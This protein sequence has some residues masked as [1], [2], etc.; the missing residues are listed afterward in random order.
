MRFLFL[1]NSFTYALILASYIGQ[2]FGQEDPSASLFGLN[3]VVDIH[4]TIKGEE[5]DKLKPPADVRLDGQA[6]SEAFGDLI[7]DAQRGGHFRSQKS[8]RPGLAGYLGVDHQ[9]GRADVEIDGEIVKDVGLRYKG[10]GTF[11][12]GSR[13]DRYSFKIDFNENVKGQEFRGMTKI[14]LNN[15]ITDPSLM[16]EALSYDLF[17]EAKIAASRVGYARVYLTI[18]DETKREIKRKPIGLFTLVEQKDKRFLRL[19]YGSS[20]GLLMKPSTF[21]LF[22]YLGEEIGARDPCIGW[23]IRGSGFGH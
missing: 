2:A 16:R 12:E 14:N 19:N 15:N 11:I 4:I 6:V 8:T 20:K 13:V 18:P 9:Y 10:N 1:N 22:R 23:G 5:F 21:G 3:N 7:A 17:R